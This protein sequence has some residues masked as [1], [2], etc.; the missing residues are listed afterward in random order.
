M[1]LEASIDAADGRSKQAAAWPNPVAGAEVEDIA[2]TGAYRG[3]AQSQTT[4]TISEPLEFGG[5]RGARAAAGRANLD[6]ARARGVQQRADFGFDLAVAFATAEAA[7]SRVDLLAQD[8]DRVQEDLR[9]AHAL[10]AAGKEGE[11]RVVQIDAAVAAAEAEL[12]SARAEEIAALTRLGS[13]VGVENNYTSVRPSLLLTANPV[14][15]EALDATESLT[16]PTIQT[17]QADREFADRRLIVEQR[18]AI[19]T[20]SLSV[21]V[22]RI[23]GDDATVWVAGFSIPIPL[24]DRNRGEIAAAHAD[25]RAA[26][27]RLNAARLEVAAQRRAVAARVIATNSRLAATERGETAAREAYRLARIGYEAGR[28]PLIELLSTRRAFTDAQLHSLDAR[29][30]RVEAEASLARLAGRIPFVE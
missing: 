18:R 13:L 14:R 27:A 28:T 23:A 15:A 6:V 21:G 3:T 20:P 22:R 30:A 25:V 16:E 9:I 4:L 2:G 7:Q 26:D 29:L 1:E 8:S 11:L 19:P 5:Q 17:A 24:F 12:A 10:V